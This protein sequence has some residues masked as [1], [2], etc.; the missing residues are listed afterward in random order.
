MKHIIILVIVLLLNHSITTA[1]NIPQSQVPPIVL[2]HFRQTF[3]KAFDVEWE[4]KNNQYH[5]E[6]E[7]RFSIDHEVWYDDAGKMI[8]H[9]EETPYR[10]FPNA[11][12]SSIKRSFKEYRVEDTKTI[13]TDSSIQYSAEL[14]SAKEEWKVLFDK[15]GKIL[16]QQPD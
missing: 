2:S 4:I 9:E 12:Q 15:N 6:F 7:T 5:V 8:R 11:V 13:T 14:K 3:P 1:Q 16:S 10:K